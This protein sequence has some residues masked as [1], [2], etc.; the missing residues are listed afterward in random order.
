[1]ERDEERPRL[2]P[3]CRKCGCKV[4]PG[5][6]TLGPDE[7]AVQPR[8][9]F[10]PLGDGLKRDPRNAV[11]QLTVEDEELAPTC[12]DCFASFELGAEQGARDVREAVVVARDGKV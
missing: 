1:M 7:D 11:E 3:V 6:S 10:G 12:G 4:V 8:R 2:D 9:R 5:R